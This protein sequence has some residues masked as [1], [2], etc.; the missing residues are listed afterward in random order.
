M[1]RQFGIGEGVLGMDEFAHRPVGTDEV[2]E[3]LDRFPIHRDP[4]RG[5][6]RRETNGIGSG[7]FAEFVEA[8]PLAGEVPRQALG[9]WIGDHPQGF[10]AQGGGIGE[11]ALVGKFEQPA[12]GHGRPEEIR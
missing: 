10:R 1:C 8:Q 3:A 12:V 5:G 9:P 4:Q 11:F 2:V 7:D 6:E